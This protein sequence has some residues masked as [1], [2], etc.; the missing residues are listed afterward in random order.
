MSA[1]VELV[2]V[3][4]LMA[5]GAWFLINRCTIMPDLCQSA[6]AQTS[7]STTTTTT[8]DVADKKD[9]GKKKK[10]GCCSCVQNSTNLITCSV[11]GGGSLQ[12]TGGHSLANQCSL[13][14]TDPNICKNAKTADTTNKAITRA[15]QNAAGY[16]IT[17]KNA[18]VTNTIHCGS[19]Y[20]L[21][22]SGVCVPNNSSKN[23]K[24]N[25]GGDSAGCKSGETYTNCHYDSSLDK[26]VCTCANYAH[27]VPSYYAS[28]RRSYFADTSNYRAFRNRI[29]FG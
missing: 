19:G 3:I 11:P 5:G 12:F 13:C 29:S 25:K 26:M 7:T 27:V 20:S 15:N 23:P 14:A 10:C 24:P 28:I 6:S 17:D 2:M 22:K 9:N 8:T 21:S 4:G 18:G 16:K 1:I